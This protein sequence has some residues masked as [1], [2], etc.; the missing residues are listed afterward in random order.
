MAEHLG[1]VVCGAPL[2]ART[3]EVAAAGVAAGWAVHVIAT[4]SA[5]GWLDRDAVERVTG[6]PVLVEQR[7]PSEPKRFPVPGAVVVCPA[8]FNTVNKVAAGIAD[9]YPTGFICEALGAGV[10]LTFVPMVSERLWGHPV[11]QRNLT[12]LSGAGA[13]ILD[14]AGQP[15]AAPMRPDDTDHLVTTFNPAP[16]FPSPTP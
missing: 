13:R 7:G 8:T 10:P 14:V 2:A 12:L 6:F 9:D 15:T 16:L 4:R 1:L 5:L 11:W 3:H